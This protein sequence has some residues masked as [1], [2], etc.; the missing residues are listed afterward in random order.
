MFYETDVLIIGAGPS[1]IASSIY[2]KRSNINF[3]IV[4]KYIT[5]GKVALTAK[6]DNYPGIINA[7]GADFALKLQE[8]LTSNKIEVVYDEIRELKKE[9][10]YFIGLGSNTYK[11]KKV[12][13][14]SGTKEKKLNLLHE[15]ELIGRGISF[16]AVCD[17]SLYKEKDVALVGGGNSCLE[18]ALYL[19]SIAK[20]VYIIHRRNE[21]RCDSLVLDLVKEKNNIHLLTPFIVEE[22]KVINKHLKGVLLE[23]TLDKSI[24]ELNV[25]GLF[26]YI[27]YEPNISYIKESLKTNNGFI[28]TDENME[29]S[30][31]GLYAV[32][33][34]RE[35]KLRQV[36]TATSDGAICAIAVQ[37]ALKKEL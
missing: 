22:Y 30:I 1:G 34:I 2:L 36:V 4:E 26:L 31:K 17:G 28:I 29:S 11:V 32:G 19:A 3:V 6:I 27:G 13:I 9:N 16:C 37:N 23:N 20:N 18:E 15:D 5:G 10:N 14:A 12:I 21:F 8:H 35:K 7:D 33:D 25:D 24:K